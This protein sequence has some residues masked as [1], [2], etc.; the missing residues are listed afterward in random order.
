TQPAQQHADHPGPRDR[1]DD[2]RGAGV[3]AARPYG[4]GPPERAAVDPFAPGSARP[5]EITAYG[6]WQCAADYTWDV[7]HPVLAKPC[8]STGTGIKLIGK[9]SGLPGVQT[10]VQ[11][12]L[13]DAQSGEVVSGPFGCNGLLFTDFAPTHDCGP[14]EV[15]VPH[16]RTLAVKESWEYTGRTVLPSGTVQGPTFNW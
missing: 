15:N 7:G 5:V 16:G 6:P 12:A 14:F 4:A 3:A 8:H 1:R 13:V 11:V 2:A 10:D 9:M